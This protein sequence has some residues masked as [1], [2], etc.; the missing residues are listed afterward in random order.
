MYQFFIPLMK[1]FPQPLL[2]KRFLPSHPLSSP[3]SSPP[4][5]AIPPPPPKNNPK[6]N[7]T[8]NSS[9]HNP[10]KPPPPC[11]SQHRSVLIETTD[12]SLT[13]PCVWSIQSQFI[14]WPGTFLCPCIVC[15]LKPNLK[16]ACTIQC[17]YHAVHRKA[18]C[19]PRCRGWGQ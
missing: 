9:F 18:I 4:P 6:T 10:P 7:H 1:T 5:P 11:P 16:T 19:Q 2:P 15:H 17:M 12:K 8:K 13:A 3:S 14:A